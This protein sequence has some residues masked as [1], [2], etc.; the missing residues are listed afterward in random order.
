[1][2]REE[3]RVSKRG[4]SWLGRIDVLARGAVS[5]LE[6]TAVGALLVGLGIAVYGPH[7]VRGGFMGDDWVFRADY[8]R[9]GYWGFIE[10]LLDPDSPESG[11][12][13]PGPALARPVAVVFYATS[14]RLLGTSAVPHLA[15]ALCLG[16]LM[17]FLLFLVLRK[18]GM[19]RLH[20]AAIAA[21]VLLFPAADSPRLWPAA[22]LIEF[23]ISLFLLG[24]LLALGGLERTGRAAVLRHAAA[25]GCYVL[26][27]LCYELVVGGVLLTVLVYRL[28]APWRTAVR[29]WL[30]DIAALGL[31]AAYVRFVGRPQDFVPLS[32]QLET[33]RTIQGQARTLLSRLGIQD[34]QAWVDLKVL[35]LLL[36][37]A[38]ALALFLPRT[39]ELRGDLR[40]WVVAALAGIVAVGAGYVALLPIEGRLPLYAGVG[41]RVNIGAA[42]GYVVLIYALSVLAGTM[43]VRA[44]SAVRT[45]RHAR[46]WAAGF[47][48]AVAFAVGLLWT[49]AVVEDRR[50]WDRAESIRSQTLATL[51]ELPRPAPGSTVYTFGVAGETAPGVP[52]FSAVW[53]LTGA[54]RV[55]WKD[56][57]LRA[58]P[59]SS[60]ERG[61]FGHTTGAFGI[62]CTPSSV[63]P[64]GRYS[65]RDAS[66][67][68]RTIFVHIPSRAYVLIRDRRACR[69]AVARYFR[70][71]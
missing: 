63:R 52:T 50:A 6:A 37:A 25:V 68:G 8:E 4:K 48:V 40:R 9:F 14:Y 66:P 54:V 45:V 7:V 19:E 61:A 71:T 60:L 44:L 26:G 21:L 13:A 29:R 38:A 28:R 53:D 39:D 56:H 30:V 51:R 34:G 5:R 58:I 43:V 3:G 64:L 57:T 55:L 33:A 2:T 59:S 32:S 46:A 17:S 36:A 11:P 22:A 31:A 12:I 15:L 47:G 20:A 49:E 1:V 27:I 16:V 35:A 42:A 23:A 10:Q 62:A 41:N 24:L 69:A 65:P 67:Y 18:L 70:E